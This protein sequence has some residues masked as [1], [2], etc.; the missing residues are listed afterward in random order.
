MSDRIVSYL[1]IHSA[2]Q[3]CERVK[4]FLEKRNKVWIVKSGSKSAVVVAS[5]ATQ[6]K[7]LSDF[8]NVT[9]VEFIDLDENRLDYIILQ[10]GQEDG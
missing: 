2:C 6:A 7:I 8:I 4:C 3:V 5:D 9:S 1:R 10:N